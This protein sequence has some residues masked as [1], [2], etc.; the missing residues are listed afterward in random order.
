MIDKEYN[1][2]S[3]ILTKLQ[4]KWFTTL[5]FRRW[6]IRVT[7]YRE[8]C[9]DNLRTAGSCSA[10]WQ[11]QD[12]W[13]KFYVLRLEDMTEK[14]IEEIFVHECGH[15]LVN[16]MREWQADRMC[17]EEHVVTQLTQALLWTYY[18]GKQEGKKALKPA[19]GK[20]K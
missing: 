9:E 7:L 19:K 12:V 18:D 13:L 10:D 3:R 15:I 16:E 5:G 8:P 1:R 17:H 14:E 4:R 2:I 6:K 20:K 11:Y